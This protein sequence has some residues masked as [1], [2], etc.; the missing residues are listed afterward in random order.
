MV[1]L[2]NP[3]IESGH[4]IDKSGPP[5]RANPID[6]C[7]LS[8]GG[9]D[10]VIL[11][12]NHIG[13]Y[14]SEGIASTLKELDGRNI[15]HTGA[16]MTE[17]EARKPWIAE[18]SGI[19]FAVIAQAEYEFGIASGDKPGAAAIDLQHLFHQI[20]I[21]KQEV[22]FVIV[23]IHG[24]N[25]LNPFP[26][27]D[28][29]KRYRLIADFGADAVIGMHPHCPQGYEVYEGKPI[30]YST[31]NFFFQR[32]YCPA[33]E[34]WYF[35]YLPILSLQKGSG[36]S[37]EIVPYRFD[38][39]CTQISPLECDD[40]EKFIDYIKR[41]SEC[42]NNSEEH[43]LLFRAWCLHAG[44][45]YA[46]WFLRFDEK[47]VDDPSACHNEKILGLRN[48][49][50]CEAHNEL[51][52]ELNVMVAEGTEAQAREKLGHVI[53]S[54]KIPVPT[55]QDKQLSFDPSIPPILTGKTS[56][57]DWEAERR[58]ELLHLIAENVY[59]FCPTSD[60][61]KV[62]FSKASPDCESM[63][64]M[65][66]RKMVNV[67]VS[68]KYGDFTFPFVLF[69]PKNA[70]GKCPATLFI[71]NRDPELI[72]PD[73]KVISEFWPAEEIVKRGYAAAAFHTQTVD[74]DVDD[75]FEN[76]I[77]RIFEKD[78]KN[79]SADAWATIAA[80]AFG[81]SRILD[82][83][84]TDEMIDSKHISIIGHSRGGKTA[85]WAG[86]ND[87]R[88][89]SVYSND[90]GCSGA[91]LTREKIGEHLLNI[92]TAMPFWFNENYKAYNGREREMPFDQHMLLALIAP[93]PLYVASASLDDW[94]DPKSE[95]KSLYLANEVYKV[96]GYDAN[97]P[98]ALPEPEQ[99]II[100]ERMGHHIRIGEH[101]LTGYDWNLYLNFLDSVK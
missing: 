6:L 29:K 22:D 100:F 80:W 65:A 12:N 24:G 41:N 28:V 35:G 23:V 57:K 37:F 94:S 55:V 98:S 81:A 3:V 68:A 27:P 96:Y 101:N 9:F 8:D 34:G 10:C 7:L 36:V 59:G 19:K 69:I 95:Y 72:D 67:T 77:I 78:L 91:A 86:A 42:L 17:D 48:L 90:S 11:A 20:K 4:P 83:L 85:L 44:I 33:D 63:D 50:T 26:S 93:R 64:G 45:P 40:K 87:E 15:A 30:F 52:R 38:P 76:G 18:K 92:N 21:L 73:R 71:N 84:V 46:N 62:S 99:Q 66:I 51:M 75:G 2:E 53:W 39:E 1:N 89:Y 47:N 13:D 70:K 56:V 31:G 60:Q 25:E 82:Y 61:Y 16:G 14:G 79:R 58:P 74:T 5:L 54:Q 32:D 88:F 43:K 49:W 97:L